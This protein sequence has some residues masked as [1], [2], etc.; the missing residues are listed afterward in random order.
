MINAFVFLWPGDILYA[1]A[2]CGLFLYSMRNLKSRTLLIIA[3][4]FNLLLAAK[5]FYQNY[6]A[7][8]TR[9][10]GEQALA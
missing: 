3:I 9:I 4:V 1:Y 5:V 8:Q 6:D 7:G 10:N 2:I